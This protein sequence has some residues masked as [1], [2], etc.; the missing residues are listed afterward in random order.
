MPADRRDHVA[1][2]DDPDRFRRSRDEGD[3]LGLIPRRYQSGEIAY[4]GGIS[5]YGDVPLGRP[6]LWFVDA[7]IAI[8]L[9]VRTLSGRNWF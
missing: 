2:I 5:K 1:A 8:E 7:T 4:T 3:Y 9:P 6:S